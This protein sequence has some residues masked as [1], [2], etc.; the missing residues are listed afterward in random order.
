MIFVVMIYGIATGIFIGLTWQEVKY[1]LILRQPED[2]FVVHYDD[3][4]HKAKLYT[5]NDGTLVVTAI[6]G[7]YRATPGGGIVD[8]GSYVKRW[9]RE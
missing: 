9:Y 8:K 7:L 5:L 2:V 1:S 3:T 4:I 6:V